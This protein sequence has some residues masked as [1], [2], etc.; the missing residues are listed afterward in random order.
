MQ[1]KCCESIFRVLETYTC[2]NGYFY[3][4]FAQHQ[5]VCWRAA[6]KHTL[7]VFTERGNVIK[8]IELP[9]ILNEYCYSQFYVHRDSLFLIPR[10]DFYSSLYLNEDQSKWEILP[11]CRVPLY[12]DVRFEVTSRCSGEWGGTAIFTDKITGGQ[13]VGAAICAEFVQKW[14]HSYYVTSYMP[15]LTTSMS[16]QRIDNPAEMM[17]FDSLRIHKKTWME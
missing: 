17:P 13:Y 10:K 7:Y 5:P 2:Y 1:P 3:A 16:I 4:I 9:G 15:H 12:E 6:E 11:N 8:E 14:G